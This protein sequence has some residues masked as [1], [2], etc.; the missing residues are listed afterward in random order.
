V[1][2]S[3]PGAEAAEQRREVLRL[4]ERLHRHKD[5]AYGDAWRKRGEVIAIFANMARKYDRLIVAFAERRPAATEALG[6]TVGDLC[7]Y[8]AKYLTWI[9]EQH[10]DAFSAAAIGI[11]PSSVIPAHGPEPLAAAFA[12]LGNETDSQIP[13]SSK[14]SWEQVQQSFDA[15]DRAL[16]AQSIPDSPTTALLDFRAKTILAWR[17]CVQLSWLLALLECET[18]GTLDALRSE[19]DEMDQRA[20]P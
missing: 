18:P 12:V 15:L 5:A 4:L 10:P 7:V 11:D 3:V 2:G 17:L 1:S 14:E 6:D 19:V 13:P 9:A 20:A 16:L 8:T